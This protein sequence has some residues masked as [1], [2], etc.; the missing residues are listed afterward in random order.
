M[1]ASGGGLLVG[2]DTVVGATTRV[3]F[4]LGTGQISASTPARDAS[5]DV[6][7]RTA[8]LYAGGRGDAFQWQAGAL[9]GQQKIRTHR[10]ATLGDLSA[11]IGSDDDAHAAQ[12]YVEGAYVIDG[13]RGS[14]APFVNVAYQQ[15][16]TP[17]IHEHG[18]IG[19]LDVDADRSHQTFGTLGLRGEAKLG[20]TG[21][22]VFGSLGWRH[23]WGD[24]DSTARMRFAGTGMSFDIQGVPVADDAGVVTAGLR[25]RPAPSVTVDATYSGQFAGDAKDQSARLSL[26]WA[27]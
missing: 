19:A 15:L 5:A 21:T 6:R 11:R 16:R 17:T 3:G 1:S 24:V 8:G 27:F 14:W 10:T 2:A 25:F 22:A 26:S 7:T 4:A 9:Y 12:G 20:D 13:T 23:G 18:S